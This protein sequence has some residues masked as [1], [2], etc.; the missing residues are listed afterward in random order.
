MSGYNLRRQKGQFT[1]RPFD[2][3]SIFPKHCTQIKFVHP[4]QTTLSE[5]RKSLVQIMHPLTYAVVA[6]VA[7]SDSE[8]SACEVEDVDVTEISSAAGP[9]LARTLR[10]REGVDD[11]AIGVAATTPARGK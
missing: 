10:L 7:V 6:A 4:A 11:E 9:I 2:T 5:R 1:D 3:L 8:I